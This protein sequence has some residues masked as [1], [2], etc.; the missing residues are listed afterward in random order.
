MRSPWLLVL[1]VACAR[2]GDA[3]Q[4]DGPTMTGD[5]SGSGSG[6]MLGTPDHCG[7]CTMACPGMDGAS[8]QRTCSGSTSTATCG[9]VCGGEFYDVDGN[10]ANGCE[11][12]DVPVQD[13]AGTAVA[14]MLPNVTGGTGA[15]TGA[16][17]PCT[18]TGQIYGD[19]RFH[20][21]P[22]LSR[23]L[24]RD[25]WYVVT[26]VGAGAGGTMVACLGITNFPADNRYE[27]C[28]GNSGSTTPTSCMTVIGGGSSVCVSPPTPADA[29]TFFVR[30]SKASGS[31]TLNKYALYV[32]H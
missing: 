22:P 9:I 10:A 24:G 20:E 14:I 4:P 12:E 11:A 15:C 25:D 30:I 29:G 21:E 3:D 13:T 7:S 2:G 31:L 17:N 23:V 5:G 1:L 28:I 19:A 6:C 27:V 32:S 26:A 8:T 16:N 18:Q